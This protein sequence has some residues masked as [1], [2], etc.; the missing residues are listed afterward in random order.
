M[1]E[2]AVRNATSSSTN[3]KTAL[4]FKDTKLED[5][6]MPI[7]MFIGMGMAMLIYNI[8]PEIAQIEWRPVS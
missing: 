1:L 4:M 6:V 5:A 7:S 2:L 8:S 3:D